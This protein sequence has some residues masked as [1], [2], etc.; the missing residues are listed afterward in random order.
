M[1]LCFRWY[2]VFKLADELAVSVQ[3]SGR[4]VSGSN[5]LEATWGSS[6]VDIPYLKLL[7]VK[8]D[9]EMQQCFS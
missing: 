1:F 2:P 8:V 3:T 5:I 9:T 7:S 6:L 4:Y